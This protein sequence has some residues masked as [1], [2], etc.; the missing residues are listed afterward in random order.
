MN[1]YDVIVR[2]VLT[3]KSYA[4]IQSKVYNFIV[5]KDATKIDIKNAI[6]EIF[7]VDVEKVNTMNYK[8]STK[9]MNT[10]AGRTKGTTASFK[11]AIVTLKAESKPIE[12]FESLN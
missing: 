5:N 9:T 3:E 7:K 8:A 10:K 6:K 1:A 2:P 11:K 12:F 4:V